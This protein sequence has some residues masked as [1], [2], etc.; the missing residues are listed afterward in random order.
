VAS[1]CEE[2]QT[3]LLTQT[4]LTALVG[5]RIYPAKLPQDC[6][7]PAV[8]YEV[9]NDTPVHTM[10]ADSANPRKPLITYNIWASTYSSGKAVAEQLRTA[11]MDKTGTLTVRVLQWIFWENEYDLYEDDTETHHIVTDFIVWYT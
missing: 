3:Y 2:L 10:S 11:L 4:G 1:I 7:L 5:H 6:T 9:T 8:S